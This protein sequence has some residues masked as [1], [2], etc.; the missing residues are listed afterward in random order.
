MILA[1]N[2]KNG[3]AKPERRSLRLQLDSHS[4][5]DP[6]DEIE[7]GGNRRNV[8]NGGVIE[9][10]RTQLLDIALVDLARRSRQFHRIR[11][12]GAF[13]GIARLGIAGDLPESLSVMVDSIMAVVCRGHGYGDH[14]A[15]AP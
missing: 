6:V 2:Q 14:F 11:E 3:M 12:Q 7:V 15:L 5:G 13:A 9:A 10:A 8:V 4:Q 1:G